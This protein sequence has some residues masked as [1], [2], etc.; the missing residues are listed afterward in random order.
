MPLF[1]FHRGGLHDSL[2]TTVIVDSIIELYVVISREANETC[3]WSASIEIEP[4]PMEG[5]NFDKRI[6]WFTHLVSANIYEQDKYH[7][8]GF[9]SEPLR[10]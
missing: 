5:K 6:G 7:P 1:R 3:N 9:L 8:I 4:Y 2:Q 10:R